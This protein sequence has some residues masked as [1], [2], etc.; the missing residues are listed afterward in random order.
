MFHPRYRS[1]P[2]GLLAL[3]RSSGGENHVGSQ[4]HQSRTNS[5][6]VL[7]PLQ[8]L[9]RVVRL[10]RVAQHR[11]GP[12]PTAILSPGGHYGE[13]CEPGDSADGCFI[14]KMMT[15]GRYAGKSSNISRAELNFGEYIS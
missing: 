4:S 14:A 2:Q 8:L 3:R 6:S 12:E 11:L 5:Q 10:V 13:Q 1:R 15:H 9:M 7:P